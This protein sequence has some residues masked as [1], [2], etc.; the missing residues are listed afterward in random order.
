MENDMPLIMVGITWFLISEVV[1]KGDP[2]FFIVCLIGLMVFVTVVITWGSVEED[3]IAGFFVGG[4]FGDGDGDG[5]GDG[6]DGD[7]GGCGGCG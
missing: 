2:S 1:A 4:I 5:D 6:G 7:G 3:G